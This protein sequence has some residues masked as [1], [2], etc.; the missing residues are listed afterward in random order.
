M[1]RKKSSR[2][3]KRKRELQKR[4]EK[5]RKQKSVTSNILTESSSDSDSAAKVSHDGGPKHSKKRKRIGKDKSLL[6][7]NKEIIRNISE[8]ITPVNKLK[9]RFK[10]KK[11]NFHVNQTA[12]SDRLS[13]SSPFDSKQHARYD[14]KKKR[15]K[16]VTSTPLHPNTEE[17]L[18][19]SSLDS[20]TI[21]DSETPP[22]QT[23]SKL[24][25]SK[26]ENSPKS[27]NI[28]KKSLNIRKKLKSIRHS[29]R[30][31]SLKRVQRKARA[32]RKT[33]KVE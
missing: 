23:A 14:S 27:K 1:D 25:E 4:W 8:E 2:K 24:S 16:I 19:L 29:P 11:L 20:N 30:L 18:F 6:E 33:L 22:K 31:S 15:D 7:Q 5:R 10:Q 28:S 26:N 13:K 32:T 17:I 12:N 21:A 3:A 9:A